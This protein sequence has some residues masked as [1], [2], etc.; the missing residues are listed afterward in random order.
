[1]GLFSHE[2]CQAPPQST[3]VYVRHRPETTL[4]YQVVHEYWP[5]FQAELARRV[6]VSVIPPSY[7]LLQFLEEVECHQQLAIWVRN[8]LQHK[9]PIIVD[10]HCVAVVEHVCEIE[11][12]QRKQGVL[13]QRA[14]RRVSLIF[15]HHQFVIAIL[16]EQLLPVVRP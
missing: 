13:C 7:P 16:I 4:L 1:M 8:G 2:A 11:T 15:H 12:L 5:E 9:K 6:R 14:K 3:A 10:I